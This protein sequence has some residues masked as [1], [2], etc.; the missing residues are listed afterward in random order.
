MEYKKRP[1]LKYYEDAILPPGSGLTFMMQTKKVLQ[2][3]SSGVA[4]ILVRAGDGKNYEYVL[5]VGKLD[6]YK[7]AQI[8][9]SQLESIPDGAWATFKKEVS[10]NYEGKKK[11]MYKVELVPGQTITP[12]AQPNLVPQSTPN[13]TQPSLAQPSLVTPAAPVVPAPVSLSMVQDAIDTTLG[14]P[15]MTPVS[16]EQVLDNLSEEQ[17]HTDIVAKINAI[18]TPQDFLALKDVLMNLSG[19]HDYMVSI[20]VY[21]VG[22]MYQLI[23]AKKF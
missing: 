23:E 4:D 19:S 11:T 13:L 6:Q 1:S 12:A 21:S 22:K 17:S 15:P 2:K 5:W 8:L 10:T 7:G 20:Y 16:A 18:Q 3:L 9:W 14:V